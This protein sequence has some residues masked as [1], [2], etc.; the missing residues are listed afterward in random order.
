MCGGGGCWGGV[1]GEKVLKKSQKMSLVLHIHVKT[2][3]LG[4]CVC[5]TLVISFD[6]LGCTTL[7]VSNLPWGAA[8]MFGIYLVFAT[9]FR[10]GFEE[11]VNCDNAMM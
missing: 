11:S 2:A 1:G 8:L 6:W 3:G 7:C 9:H 4:V 5:H 10:Y